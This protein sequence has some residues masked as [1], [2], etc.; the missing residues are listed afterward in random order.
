MF[1]RKV[2]LKNFKSFPS[3]AIQF[4]K[5]ISTIV[6][7]NGS[8]KCLRG[9][10][11][12]FLSDGNLKPIS[13]I[14][15][16]QLQASQS[17]DF[18]EDGEMTLET[19]RGISV[20]S[21]NPLTGKIEKK[22]VQAF[23]KRKSPEKL[24]EIKTAGGKSVVTTYYHPVLTIKD[25]MITS[26]HADELKKGSFIA[27]PR[28]FP[29]EEKLLNFVLELAKQPNSLYLGRGCERLRTLL[30]SRK[31]FD[32]KKWKQIASEA[33]LSKTTLKG[34]IDGQSIKLNDAFR[35][36]QFL[37]L[38][39]I[40]ATEL[41][42]E[43]KAKNQRKAIRLPVGFSLELAK[44]LGYVISEG[45]VANNEV[46]FFNDSPELRN[47]FRECASRVFGCN[48]TECSSGEKKFLVLSSKVVTVFLDKLFGLHEKQHASRKEVPSL[49]F[50]VPLPFVKAFLSALFDGDGFVSGKKDTRACVEY[51]SA[52][53]SLVTQL[54][55]LLLRFGVVARTSAG[56]KFASNTELKIKRPYYRATVYGIEN[57]RKML[58]TLEF[59]IEKKRK[60]QELVES[61]ANKS[62][63]TNVDVIPCSNSV[64]KNLLEEAGY[65]ARRLKFVK[66]SKIR[67]YYENRCFPT[68][69]GLLEVISLLKKTDADVNSE[70]LLTLA[71][72][73]VFWDRIVELNETAGVEWVYDLC[74][75]GNHNFLAEG[76]FVHNS[77]VIDALLF[78]FGESS[79]KSMRVRK[80][81]DL[82]F[83]DHNV[84]EATVALEG[85]N[86]EK[87]EVKRF[88]RKDG[89]TKYTLDG[90]RAKKYVVEDFLAS[91]SIFK[92]NII[93]QGEVQRIVEMS[94][95]NRRTLID[96]IA[97]ISEYEQKKA[98]AMNELN[99]VDVRM[100][101]AVAILNEKEGY[102]K[103]LRKEKEDAE[104]F[105]NLKKE[106]ESLKATLLYLDVK[107]YEKD[108]EK[109]VN[110]I[111]DLNSKLASVKELIE[112]HAKSIS[113]KFAEKDSINQQIMQKGE[114]KQILLQKEI[115]GLSQEIEKARKLIDEKREF[116]SRSEG[117][118]MELGLVMKRAGDEI[119]GCEKQVASN[120]SEMD[121][122][123]RLLDAE[124]SEY[125]KLMDQSKNFSSKFYEAKQILEQ[126]NQE[127]LAC[128]ES[129][130]E[131][132]SQVS[133]LKE[134]QELKKR[135]L[136]R[137][138]IGVFD[139]LGDKRKELLLKREKIQEQMLQLD[140]KL[141]GLLEKEKELSERLTVLN[142]LILL[143][144]EKI[145]VIESRLEA[146]KESEVSKAVDELSDL[147]GVYGTVEALC[148]YDSRYSLPIQV[149]L[150]PRL[151]YVVVDSSKTARKAIE[152]LKQRKLGRISFIPLD[153]IKPVP[154]GSEDRKL[155]SSKG[156]VDFLIDL[157]EFNEKYRKAF[158]FVCGNT[159]LM[160]TLED[161]EELIGRTRMVTLE[162]ELIEPSG[163]MTGGIV[164]EKINPFKER[165]DLEEWNKKLEESRSEKGRI[166]EELGD[167]SKELNE[168][169]KKKAEADLSDKTFQIELE[170]L[171]G[172]EMS[173]LEKKKNIAAA[174]KSLEEEINVLEQEVLAGD[175]KRAELIRKLS[176]LNI[177]ALDAKQKI[178]FEKE[179]KFGLM[180]KEK[181]HK[182]SE[183]KIRI[184]QYES[185]LSTLKTQKRYYEKEH[186]G[187]ESSVAELQ[188]EIEKAKEDMV[189]SDK[190]IKENTLFLREK[191]KEQ[192]E[193]SSTL[194]DLMDLRDKLDKELQKL[195]NE[196]GKMEFERERIEREIQEHQ[197]RRVAAETKLADL[198][199]E[200]SAFQGVTVLERT[201]E[202][203]PE[204][205]SRLKEAQV[206]LDAIGSVNLKALELFDQKVQEFDE[207]N[208][209]VKQLLNEKEAVL[210]L[211]REI[212]GKKVNTFMNTFNLINSNF[213]RLFSQIF[214]GSGCLFLE[215]YGED[216]KEKPL[217]EWGL[218][219][220][221]QLE[222]KEFKYL[223]LMSGGEKAL[224]AL[225]F[226]FS[227][228]MY[229]P[230]SI[231][232]LDEA[233]AALDQENS[234]KLVALLK[235]LS[236]DSQFIVVTHNETVYRKADCLVGV[237]MSKEG[238]K[239]VEVKLTQ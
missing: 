55:F 139:D 64:I 158:E 176:D 3:A 4:D 198:K 68:R 179:Q 150:G 174:I 155:K 36:T 192:K 156:A 178:D 120:Q 143:A 87:H 189:E 54:S 209:R 212:E 45:R 228:Q 127:M 230:S 51:S 75:E 66:P 215:K 136:E 135:E 72:S 93:K 196:K 229:N 28:E 173:I 182:I 151:T 199:A 167:L 191:I 147:S 80:T 118:S 89:K 27:T 181:E 180:I 205:A 99:A 16:S 15:E 146:V 84:A 238:S 76:I 224:I 166:D 207:Q 129:L 111:L 34:L 117:K 232:I 119:I 161:A 133:L 101:E 177:R 73:Q 231:Y 41:L 184:S 128:R 39:Q 185:T 154:L 52:S 235:E 8:G 190:L 197:L 69:G 50:Q 194:R 71:S 214:R 193:V 163:L 57:A 65:S 237:A 218:T 19:D 121:V 130:V 104:K 208:S 86:G 202:D 5:G 115:D 61:R 96:Y 90:K 20:L 206:E 85:D 78:T 239:L 33:G 195:G 213:Q 138:R 210:N 46:F 186:F 81:S 30:R 219:I 102:L 140:E 233:D 124:Q 63:N 88:L 17:K 172:Q 106:H 107:A 148:N 175:E 217:Q 222:N 29:V 59:S 141:G 223:E 113:A 40:E 53:K 123:K 226:I 95:K 221:V 170:H 201:D 152:F 105:V 142:D 216:G 234:L 188:N 169:R 100:K 160:K 144:R 125:S 1:V 131:V 164:S 109:E 32:R 94:P 145:T 162:G 112:A 49:L 74:V 67:A 153:R 2:I 7:P 77:N 171:A 204:L 220:Q 24:L 92:S 187:Y 149:A 132:Q 108:F 70:L 37:V 203:R 26:A 134:K 12:V 114:A 79:L 62:G 42:C 22:R 48:I 38:N 13:A 103:E 23:V 6:G 126:C 56:L 200:F 225:L 47:D 122:L 60:L 25:G 83:A 21:L 211:I 44:F 236:K 91:E 10:S 82:I 97:N 116:I 11:L 58:S 18:L 168:L 183:L 137:L 31:A 227:I 14:V 157:L 43:V 35:L 9:D 159:L 165:K 98:E 110:S